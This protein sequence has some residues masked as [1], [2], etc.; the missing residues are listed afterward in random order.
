MRERGTS[1]TFLLNHFYESHLY[2][3][4]EFLFFISILPLNFTSNF[5]RF[6][7][8][9]TFHGKANNVY[10]LSQSKQHGAKYGKEPWG[11]DIMFVLFLCIYDIL[12]SVLKFPLNLLKL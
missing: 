8:E 3:R 7:L 1:N 2:E 11:N 5:F 9:G 4:R 6:P 10:I 12:I